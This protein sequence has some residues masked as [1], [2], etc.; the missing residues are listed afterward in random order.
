VTGRR[1]DG[2]TGRR[3]PGPVAER[4][5]SEALRRDLRRH[6]AR[7]RGHGTFWR[8][9]ALIGAVGWSVAVPT[10]GGALLGHY[11]D[12]RWGSGVRYTLILITAGAILGSSVAWRFIGRYRS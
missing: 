2:E 9:L 10:A 12:A 5:L 7:E 1:E 3:V 8:S 6:A 4:E 11:L